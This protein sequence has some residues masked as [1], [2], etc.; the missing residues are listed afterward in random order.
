L[1]CVFL[2]AKGALN[3]G[4]LQGAGILSRVS[5]ETFKI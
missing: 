3:L 4:F 5:G 2:Y 1:I